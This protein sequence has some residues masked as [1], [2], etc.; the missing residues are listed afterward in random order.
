VTNAS[1]DLPDDNADLVGAIDRRLAVLDE[2]RELLRA[3]RRKY[4]G[5]PTASES[6]TPA[7]AS[8]VPPKPQPAASATPQ[9]GPVRRGGNTP[10]PITVKPGGMFETI[11]RI[12]GEHPDGIEAAKLI[13]L[14]VAVVNT[15]AGDPRGA[16]SSAARRMAENG[17]LAK[18]GGIY[19]P[20]R[21]SDGHD[22]ARHAENSTGQRVMALSERL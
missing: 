15:N 21:K 20:P 4:A 2:E 11:G 17:H 10:P 5:A 8:V 1:H 3:L 22:G 16:A 14:V 12:V 18:R 13:D 19:Y 6:S 9:A 7:G